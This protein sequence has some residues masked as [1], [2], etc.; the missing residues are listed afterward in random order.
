MC[1]TREEEG[2]GRER[3]RRGGERGGGERGYEVCV[4]VCVYVHYAWHVSDNALHN[5]IRTS[6]CTCAA[7]IL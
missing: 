7:N 6:T 4:C 1:I 5:I 3:E 2:R